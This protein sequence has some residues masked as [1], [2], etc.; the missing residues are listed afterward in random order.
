M[1]GVEVDLAEVGKSVAVDPASRHEL[2]GSVD[3]VGQ[4]LVALSGRAVGHELAVPLVD[5]REGGEPALS[6]GPQ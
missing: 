4:V 1:A 5:S 2:D 3:L 6:E